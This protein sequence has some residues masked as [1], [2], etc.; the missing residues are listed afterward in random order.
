MVYADCMEALQIAMQKGFIRNDVPVRT[1]A[2]AILNDDK[3]A[4]DRIDHRLRPQDIAEFS[5]ALHKAVHDVW[6]NIINNT[7]LDDAEHCAVVASRTIVIDIQDQIFNAALLQEDDFN[8]G[9]RAV[10]VRHKNASMQRR[11]YFGVAK[12]LSES[13][14]GKVIEIP[15]DQ[16]TEIGEPAPPTPPLLTRI[17]YL[18]LE[19]II[20]RIG[21]ILCRLMPIR[22]IRGGIFVLR[23]NELLKETGAKL[24]MRGFGLYSLTPLTLKNEV[25]EDSDRSIGEL[26][27]AVIEK[28]FKRILAPTVLKIMCSQVSNSVLKNIA[29]YRASIP[30]WRERINDIKGQKPRAVLTNMLVNPEVLGLHK[31]LKEHRIPLIVFQHGVTAEI[32]MDISR[33]GISFDNIGCDLAITFNSEMQRLCEQNPYGGAPAVSV[34]LPADYNRVKRRNSYS[35]NIWYISTSLYQ[36]NLGRLHRGLSDADIYL[37][38]IALI[39]KVF[40]NLPYRVVYKPYPAYRYLDDDPLLMHAAKHDNIEIYTKRL[41]LRYLLHKARV[42]LTTGASSTISRCLMSNRP[43]VFINSPHNMPLRDI[44]RD[45]FAR[46]MFVFDSGSNSFFKDLRE[47]LSQPIEQIENAWD[48]RAEARSKLIEKFF[49]APFSNPTAKAADAVIKKIGRIK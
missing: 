21:M 29:K 27:S 47:F 23:E 42:L 8:N 22:T 43:T 48:S 18:R 36:S 10:A 35:A 12:F 3:I 1:M 16:L 30:I 45:D 41:D 44:V 24:L 11:F 15:A 31:I 6:A 19:T 25:I 33:R 7:S 13:G 20:Y 2:P 32:S 4:V 28:R 49:S 39:D 34:G 40:T 46:A 26:I 9:T 38:E 17:S 37:H 14:Y 5:D